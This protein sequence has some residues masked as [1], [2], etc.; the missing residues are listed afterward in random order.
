MFF[1]LYQDCYFLQA[2]LKDIDTL[3]KKNR[4]IL[5]ESDKKDDDVREIK[6][7]INYVF[8]SLSI[9]LI[10][11]VSV[12]KKLEKLRAKNGELVTKLDKALLDLETRRHESNSIIDELTHWKNEMEN[13]KRVRVQVITHL[14]LAFVQEYFLLLFFIYM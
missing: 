4:E 9:F 2:K 5:I 13:E 8:L 3:N 12:R 6:S 10:V 11:H 14:T 1:S 7:N